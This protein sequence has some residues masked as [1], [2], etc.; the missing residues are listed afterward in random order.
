M[1]TIDHILMPTHLR[2]LEI[3][4]KQNS[5]PVESTSNIDNTPTPRT[6]MESSSRALP[7]NLVKMKPKIAAP[8]QLEPLEK[9]SATMEDWNLFGLKSISSLSTGEMVD[10]GRVDRNDEPH[11][12]PTRNPFLDST[13]IPGRGRPESSPCKSLLKQTVKASPS[14]LQPTPEKDNPCDFLTDLSFFQFD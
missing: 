10:D 11:R 6:M 4:D 12:A 9:D 7:P 5:E 3:V 8:P 14:S 1:L 2:Y 13:V